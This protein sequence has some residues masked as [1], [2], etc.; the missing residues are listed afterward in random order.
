MF[1]IALFYNF[2]SRIC[3]S[4]NDN[5]S[6]PYIFQRDNGLSQVDKD[7]TITIVYNLAFTCKTDFLQLDRIISKW[8]PLTDEL[9]K[10]MKKN[11]CQS[12]KMKNIFYCVQKACDVTRNININV[13]VAYEINLTTILTLA[14]HK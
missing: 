8:A 7:V 12:L 10:K 4:L 6:T 13:Y 9:C 11:F 5:S 1:A 2:A 3:L 14:S